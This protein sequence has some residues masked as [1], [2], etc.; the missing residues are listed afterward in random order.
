MGPGDKKDRK[1]KTPAIRVRV[2]VLSFLSRV[3]RWRAPRGRATRVALDMPE[4]AHVDLKMLMLAGEH[5]QA[6][7]STFRRGR[8]RLVA[9]ENVI[10]EVQPSPKESNGIGAVRRSGC[11]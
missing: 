11:P 4:G 9:R 6:V 3:P 5:L 2:R 7:M 8:V 1:D 10:L